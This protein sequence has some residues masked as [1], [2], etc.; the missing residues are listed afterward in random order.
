MSARTKGTADI[1]E[2]L[3]IASPTLAAAYALSRAVDIPVMCASGLNDV[4]VPAAIAMGAS[5]VGVGSMISK[6]S[7]RQQMLLATQALADAL[8]VQEDDDVTLDSANVEITREESTSQVF[9]Q[10]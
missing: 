3:E 9:A 7:N 10:W 6:L 8:G 2:S 1:Q 5:G 4:T